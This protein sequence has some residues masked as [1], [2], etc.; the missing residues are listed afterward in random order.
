MSAED[1]AKIAEQERRLVF[2]RFDE[3]R[4]FEI[5]GLIRARALVEK[6]PIVIEI[7]LWDRLLFYAA[8]PGATHSNAEW[9]RRKLNVVK[10]FQKSTYR[11]TLEQAPADK[12]FK[13]D[14][15]LNAA[16]YVLAGG[17]FPVRVTNV[18]VVGA[19]G[20]SGLPQRQDHGLIVDI[21][22]QHLELDPA[23]LALPS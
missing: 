4:A 19:I 10:M 18:G 5:G 20:V 15:G 16:D 6:A 1:I 14:H 23:T 21:L 12:L 17:G 9:V 11:M 3:L 7:R 8:L 22:A 2:N 13:P